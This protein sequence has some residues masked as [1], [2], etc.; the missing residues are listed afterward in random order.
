[1]AS[2]VGHPSPSSD[3]PITALIEVTRRLAEEMDRLVV[4]LNRYRGHLEKSEH[5]LHAAVRLQ[6]AARGFLVNHATRKMRAV[7]NPA[8]STIPSPHH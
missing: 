1:M 2:A 5:E 7:I 6:A 8:P 3:E 4:M